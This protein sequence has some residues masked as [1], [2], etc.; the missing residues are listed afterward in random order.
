MAYVRGEPGDRELLEAAFAQIPQGMVVL[1]RHLRYVAINEAL[2]TA[3]G[4]S[5]ADHVGHSAAEVVPEIWPVVQPWVDR[6]L[7][8]ELVVRAWAD[9]W[10]PRSGDPTPAQATFVPVRVAGDGEEQVAGVVVV[11]QDVSDQTRLRQQAEAL[12]DLTLR[13]SSADSPHDLAGAAGRLCRSALGASMCWLVTRDRA[14]GDLAFWPDEALPLPAEDGQ[15]PISDDHVVAE[16]FR[17][18]EEIVTPEGGAHDH[19]WREDAA[20]SAVHGVT[21]SAT[22][23]LRIQDKTVGVL[24]LV[25]DSP[26]AF[27]EPDLTFLRAIA[28]RVGTSV[29]RVIASQLAEQ[30]AARAEA[31]L[32]PLHGSTP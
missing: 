11:V 9:L 8:G 28:A 30:A 1:D 20:V 23:P 15:M 29:E 10:V 17:S 13:L 21:A 3:N 12:S 32:R 14:T 18:G 5:V 31:L 4:H 25:W 7:A 24:A 19:R 22:L 27:D 16:V 2:A 6:A 26:R